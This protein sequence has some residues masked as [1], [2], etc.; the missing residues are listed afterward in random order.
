MTYNLSN[1]NNSRS[2]GGG[3]VWEAARGAQAVTTI[4]NEW[5]NKWQRQQHN[6]LMQSGDNS[7]RMQIH[8]FMDPGSPHPSTPLPPLRA[9]L[10][11]S[12]PLSLSLDTNSNSSSSSTPSAQ[13][14]SVSA[15]PSG[16]GKNK[17][18]QCTCNLL[19]CKLTLKAQWKKA[20]YNYILDMLIAIRRRG[21]GDGVLHLPFRL[22]VRRVSVCHPWSRSSRAAGR[23]RCRSAVQCRQAHPLPGQVLQERQRE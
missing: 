8:R 9:S 23:P 20:I 5:H 14:Q 11:V 6:F 16:H 12:L 10:L 18:C 22:P 13:P 2:D 4:S 3:G 1:N 19:P 21:E 17:S 15:P 7:S